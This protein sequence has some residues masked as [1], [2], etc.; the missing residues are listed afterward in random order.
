MRQGTVISGSGH[1]IFVV[2]A[3]FGM[4]EFGEEPEVTP[5]QVTDVS[6]VSLSDFEAARS[7][8]PQAFETPEAS[9]SA[10]VDQTNE[11]VTPETEVAPQTV[12]V[13]Q[14]QAPE[15]GVAPD[16]SALEVATPEVAVDVD[17]P[18]G[19]DDTAPLGIDTPLPDA[20]AQDGSINSNNLALLA[21]ETPNLAPRIDTSAAP[22]PPKPTPEAP[23]ETPSVTPEEVPSVEPVE[24][25]D[26]PAAAPKE[27][28]TEV[29]PDAVEQERPTTP[30]AAARPKG[31]PANLVAEAE[32]RSKEA[33][34]IEAALATAATAAVEAEAE[35][36]PSE[37]AAVEAPV[38]TG[39]SLGQSFNSSEARAIGDVI[40]KSWN[41]TL[42]EGKDQYERLVVTV[43]V[44]LN[45]D[46][47]IVGGVEPV[48]P[49]SPNGDFKVAFEAARRAVLRA[50]PI[51][52]PQG[53][54]RDGDFLEIRFDPGRSA[55]SLE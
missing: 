25:P 34:A 46:G 50:Q 21:P 32:Q 47:K 39:S 28:T 38:E 19:V 35:A 51:P 37:T 6:I 27:A 15:A 55:I 31:R 44:K 53:K 48:Q 9:L 16:V 17:V 43:R 20:P 2:V 40:G 13:V 30:K 12:D 4:P 24:V 54:F 11:A 18:V 26:A 7:G 49:R 23:V 14:P 33:E 10:P 42:I 36:A 45:A 3:F 41:K 29:T 8:A 1:L 22:K 52:L 5:S